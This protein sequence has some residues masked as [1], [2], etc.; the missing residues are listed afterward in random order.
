MERNIRNKFL[1]ACF[2]LLLEF[3]W[4]DASA[5]TLKANPL[6]VG[7]PEAS[8]DINRYP[9]LVSIRDKQSNTHQCSGFLVGGTFVLTASSCVP[10]AITGSAS[11]FLVRVWCRD[12]M[13]LCRAET[14]SDVTTKRRS[15]VPAG[16]FLPDSNGDVVLLEL[17][18][19]APG[20]LLAVLP[21]PPRALLYEG[22][23]LLFAGVSS[24][25]DSPKITSK[26]VRF[27]TTKSCRQA[28]QLRGFQLPSEDVCVVGVAPEDCMGCAGAPLILNLKGSSSWQDDVGIAVAIGGADW[29]LPAEFAD[30]ARHE[31]WLRAL[32]LPEQIASVARRAEVTTEYNALMSLAAGQPSGVLGD[33]G[34]SKPV[35]EWTGVSCGP[36]QA[37][38]ALSLSDAGLV[39]TL[40]VELSALTTLTAMNLEDNEL[41]GTLPGA[42]SSLESLV[43]LWV[44]PPLP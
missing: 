25:G 9:Y 41:E 34:T 42:W 37:V 2:G 11:E 8:N 3:F 1:T 23:R 26:V 5:L 43:S 7:V 31:A 10:S 40:P 44:P 20:P 19:P 27:V 35:C 14:F 21:Q 24:D 12:S 6:E 33:W 17:D 13:Q 29:A 18:F 32:G 30:L 28:Y 15:R 38:V 16:S 39:G 4:F 36:D 22:M